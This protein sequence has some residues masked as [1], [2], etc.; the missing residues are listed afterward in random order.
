MDV[1]CF[2]EYDACDDDPCTSDELCIPLDEGLSYDCVCPDGYYD[3]DCDSGEQ[4]FLFI[5]ILQF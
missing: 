2:L 5:P 1:Y 3:S 4:H